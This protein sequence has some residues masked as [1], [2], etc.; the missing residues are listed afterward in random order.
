M[1][2]SNSS[3]TNIVAD[4]ALPTAATTKGGAT[5]D[6]TAAIWSY[7]DGATSVH[8]DFAFEEFLVEQTRRGL[9][10][11]LLW[12]A[13]NLS[14]SHLENTHNAIKK[15]VRLITTASRG[16]S[17]ERFDADEVLSHREAM[18][19]DMKRVAAL[20][21]RWH[22]LGYAGVSSSAVSIFDKLSIKGNKI[23]EAVLTRDPIKGPFTD[24]ERSG[25]EDALNQA[26]A[27]G[28]LAEDHYLLTWLFLAIGARP[29][30]FAAMKVRDVQEI[31]MHD[32]YIQYVIK[33]PRA[34]QRTDLRDQLKDRLLIPQIG[35]HLIDYAARVREQFSE[36]LDDASDAPLFP[37]RRASDARRPI[38]P[39]SGWNAYHKTSGALS[40]A[41][42]HALSKLNL[43]SERTG[44]PLRV[45]PRRFRYTLG[46]NAARENRGL[47]VIA[48]LLDHTGIQT[49]GV[50]VAA[51][52][53]MALRIEKATAL[54]LAPL[55]QAFKGVLIGSEAEAKRGNDPTSRVMDLR[56]DRSA[57]PMGSC[58]QHGFCGFLA[59][60]S[61][62]TCANFEPWLDGPHEAVLD[63][64]LAQRDHHSSDARISAVNDRTI[65]AVAEVVQLCRKLNE[66]DNQ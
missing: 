37:D 49:A 8:L 3:A 62:Y 46:T 15:F 47:L 51:G 12:Y 11:T 30:Q 53:E 27:E 13:E 63:H 55:A 38:N 54:Q 29:I 24:I 2:K 31:A 6:P 4:T 17:I 58:G 21:K 32:G 43:R 57:R 25:V 5:F 14:P 7:R 23:G 20:F 61:C 10:A 65:L 39:D 56:I 44:E 28:T 59:P 9:R 40:S 34:K 52:P 26:Y 16:K 18:K 33:V 36:L 60:I 48:E 64:L 22:A 42:T 19:H 41:L 35:K 45:N 66:G 50:Y 1:S